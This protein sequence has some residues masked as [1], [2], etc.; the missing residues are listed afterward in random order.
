MG[1][2]LRAV[3]Y[4]ETSQVVHF[5]TRNT[6]IVNLLAKGTKRPKSKSGGMVDLL[7]EGEVLF[8]CKNPETLGLLMEFSETVSRT[9]LRRDAR[10]LN[11]SLYMI[12]LVEKMLPEGDPHPPVFDLLHNTLERLSQ[13]DSPIE[14]VLGF[15]QWRFLRHVGLL[16]ELS[17]CVGCGKTV[18]EIPPNAEIYF[19]SQQGGI[20]C[21]ACNDVTN[22]KFHLTPPCLSGI[23]ALLTITLGQK[24]N[25]PESQ[26]VE[27]N[28]LLGYH[29]TH[30]LGKPLR[31]MKH[32]IATGTEQ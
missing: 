27:V 31:M 23:S 11:V 4:S 24:A 19:S 17:S 1:I 21:P 3:D 30:Q 12:E 2:C 25:L 18:M 5:L 7:A 15:F 13:S 28:R 20:L 16:G 8:S 26:G 6:G 9:T 22:E 29:I 10:R 14:A 32:V